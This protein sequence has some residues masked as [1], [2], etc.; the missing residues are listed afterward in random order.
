[1]TSRQEPDYRSFKNKGGAPALDEEDKKR[2]EELN[3]WRTKWKRRMPWYMTKSSA[4]KKGG[5]P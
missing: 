4:P 5:T 1:M 3:E 2:Q